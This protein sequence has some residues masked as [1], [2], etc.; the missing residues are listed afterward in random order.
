MNAGHDIREILQGTATTD[1]PPPPAG[2][3][4]VGT[5]GRSA[6]DGRFDYLERVA[7]VPLGDARAWLAV[8]GSWAHRC[9]ERV[10][11]AT[12]F[13]SAVRFTVTRDGSIA[14]VAADD[15]PPAALTCL[16]E[17]FGHARFRPVARP[18]ELVA[19]YRYT[20]RWS[21]P[22]GIVPRRAP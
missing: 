22:R 1:A 21:P 15:A 4:G 8:A 20:V 2:G 14:G 5:I 11:H 12:P 10:R 17:G 9:L 18:T 16:V 7:G 19:R 6:S 13:D 3:A